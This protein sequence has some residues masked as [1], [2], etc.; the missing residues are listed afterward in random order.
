MEQATDGKLY[1][2]LATHRNFKPSVVELSDGTQAFWVGE[3]HTEKIILYFHGGKLS[4]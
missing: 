3:P 1:Q 2:T 4:H